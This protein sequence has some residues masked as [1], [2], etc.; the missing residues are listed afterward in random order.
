MGKVFSG[1]GKLFGGDDVSDA[2][3]KAASIQANAQREALDYLKEVE[4]LPQQ[5]REGALTQLAGLYGVDGG[6]GSQQA[7]ID[8]AM[9]SPLYQSLLS[10]RDAGE[11]AILRNASATGGLR[12][13]NTQAALY[14]YNARLENDALL[15]AY[16]QQVQGLGGLAQLPSLA[17]AIAQQTG[18]IGSTLAQGK[19]ASAQAQQAQ[20]QQGIDNALGLASLA[21]LAFSDIRLKSNIRKTGEVGGHNWYVWDWNDEAALLDLYGQ[22]EGVMA[23][24]IYETQPE[25][26]GQ[27]NGY[28]TVN[29][30]GIEVH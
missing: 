20:Q 8:R 7:V 15:N 23:H 9:A 2:P 13:G 10:G 16:N 25:L 29:Y 18:A 28:V 14:D 11:E 26:I 5:Y 4:R 3:K 27:H 22:A 19:V 6:E 30:N 24:E 12:S 17:P 1:I 21:F